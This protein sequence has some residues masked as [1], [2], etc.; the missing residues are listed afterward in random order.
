MGDF[1]KTTKN[2][3]YPKVIW[4]VNSEDEEKIKLEICD[5]SNFIF[6]KSIIEFEKYINQNFYLV[7]SAEKIN[8]SDDFMKLIHDHP[9]CIF[10]E[11]FIPG[12]I[13]ITETHVLSRLEKN[14]KQGMWLNDILAE[15]C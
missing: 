2:S 1:I 3:I 7:Y 14:I 11:L 5:T 12:R 15:I 8:N 6:V 4:Y 9:D 10:H 13:Q